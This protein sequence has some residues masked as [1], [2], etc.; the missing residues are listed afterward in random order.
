[1]SWS[2][3]ERRKRGLPRLYGGVPG[4]LDGSGTDDGV[5]DVLGGDAVEDELGGV[6]GSVGMSLSSGAESALPLV[7][8]QATD[9][10]V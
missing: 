7:K 5:L 9:G 8:S 10:G 6:G 1:M 2:R 3:S 4:E